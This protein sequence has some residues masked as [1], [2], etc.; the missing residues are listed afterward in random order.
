MD[1]LSVV[2]IGPDDGRRGTLAQAFLEQQVTVSGELGS[3]PNFSHLVKLTESAVRLG[4]KNGLPV[5]YV[6]EDTTR[7]HPDDL[8]ALYS[9]A[10]QA[11]ATGICVCDTVGH[12]TPDGV[13]ALIGFITEVVQQENPAVK[14]DWHGHQ[15]RGLSVPNSVRLKG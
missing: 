6:T 14:I 12:A 5:N 15:D 11:G 13:R 7:A 10:I 1:S 8:R 9:A 2:L 3:Y 4:V